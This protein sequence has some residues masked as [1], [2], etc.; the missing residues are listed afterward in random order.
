MKQKVAGTNVGRSKTDILNLVQDD[1]QAVTADTWKAH[2]EHVEGLEGEYRTG[3][4]DFV[5]FNSV[6]IATVTEQNLFIGI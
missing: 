1:F 6:S 5:N 4:I 2:C 3:D